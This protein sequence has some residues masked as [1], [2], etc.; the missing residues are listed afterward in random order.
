MPVNL[1]IP[2]DIA[3]LTA[4]VLAQARIH[5]KGQAKPSDLARLGDLAVGL[6]RLARVP[7]NGQQEGPETFTGVSVNVVADALG[8]DP[9]TV[10]RKC[11]SGKYRAKRVSGIWFVDLQEV[12]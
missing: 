12:A 3:G 10:R 2:D 4:N 1:P 6:N 9:S 11:R 8:V 7:A 5:F